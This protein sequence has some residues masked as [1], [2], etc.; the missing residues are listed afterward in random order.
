[1][2]GFDVITSRAFASL[3][4]FVRLTERLLNPAGVWLAMKGKVPVD[5]IEKLGTTRSIDVMSLQVPGLHAE[6][7]IL[8]IQPLNDLDGEHP[9]T[10]VADPSLKSRGKLLQ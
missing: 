8:R 9:L 1:V 7:C 2:P 6:R 4:D 10:R 3:P 5:E